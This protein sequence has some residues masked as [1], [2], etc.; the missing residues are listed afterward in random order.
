MDESTLGK[1]YL[2]PRY[3]SVV[4]TGEEGA[5]SIQTEGDSPLRIALIEVPE[6]VNYPLY[7]EER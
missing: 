5:I 7:K 6:Q 3:F 4:H 1:H 2:E